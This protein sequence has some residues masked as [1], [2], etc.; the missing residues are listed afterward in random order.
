MQEMVIY[1]SELRLFE[2]VAIYVHLTC[3][4]GAENQG[5]L[6]YDLEV[7]KYCM[8]FEFYLCTSCRIHM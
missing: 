3:Q 8:I 1:D 5:K 2:P 7:I 4:H 6:I